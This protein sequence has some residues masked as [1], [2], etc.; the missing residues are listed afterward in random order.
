[1][2]RMASPGPGKG[3]RNTSRRGRPSS[4]PSWR[5]SSLKRPLSGSMTPLKP[6][7][8]GSPPTLWWLLI[9]ALLAPLSTMS[10]YIVPWARN[11]G[12]PH[13]RAASSKVRTNS[14]PM[15]L[16]LRSGS[17]TPAM[18]RRKRSCASMHT[19][20]SFRRAKAERI[21]SVSFLRMKPWSM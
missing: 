17:V 16:R 7:S 20:F 19:S 9:T 2:M 8:S 6:M 15:S 5:T 12:E 4:S 13:S 11:S 1:M 18:R 10:G 3:W 14:S 21:S